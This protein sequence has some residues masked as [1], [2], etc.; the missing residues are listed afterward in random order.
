MMESLES[1]GKNLLSDHLLTQEPPFTTTYVTHP[2]FL[3]FPCSACF[4]VAEYSYN[5]WLLLFLYASYTESIYPVATQPALI[6]ILMVIG[7]FVVKV[8]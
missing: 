5:S 2:L 4:K 7:C 1:R 6:I 8:P 3:H